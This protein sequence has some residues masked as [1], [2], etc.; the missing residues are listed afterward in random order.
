[1]SE[2]FDGCERIIAVISTEQEDLME[3]R[4]TAGIYAFSV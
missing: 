3:A 4:G 2:F 1:V